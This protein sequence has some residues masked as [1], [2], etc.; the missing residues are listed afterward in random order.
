MYAR[1][2]VHICFGSI[3]EAAPCMYTPHTIPTTKPT[4]HWFFEGVKHGCHRLC[5]QTKQ[6]KARNSNRMFQHQ[7]VNVVP[8]LCSSNLKPQKRESD[9]IDASIND[10]NSNI[11][12]DFNFTLPPL[13]QDTHTVYWVPMS[14]DKPRKK[15]NHFEIPSKQSILHVERNFWS[16][17]LH[18]YPTHYF[19]FNDSQT[20]L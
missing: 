15:K 8:A 17:A 12:F 7:I 13:L 9:C 14:F 11:P 18:V 2:D 4:S 16:S 20:T 3:T 10:S 5:T 19:D 6:Y 1:Y